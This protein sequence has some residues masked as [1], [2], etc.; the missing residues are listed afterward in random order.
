MPKLPKVSTYKWPQCQCLSSFL[1][2]VSQQPCP[3]SSQSNRCAEQPKRPS[4]TEAHLQALE[5]DLQTQCSK[6]SLSWKNLESVYHLLH[7]SFSL[8]ACLSNSL[9]HFSIQ[10]PLSSKLSPMRMLRAHLLIA[11]VVTFVLVNVIEILTFNL[12]RWAWCPHFGDKGNQS[13]KQLSE[14]TRV[15]QLISGQWWSHMVVW[16]GRGVGVGRLHPQETPINALPLTTM[17]SPSSK[18]KFWCRHDSWQMQAWLAAKCCS[19]CVCVLHREQS[20]AQW[21][22]RSC[23]SKIISLIIMVFSKKCWGVRS[24]WS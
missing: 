16:S 15:T 24:T 4:W 3:R 18:K 12:S 1:G 5:I 14:L 23:V 20:Y 17:P 19:N 6:V 21:T 22:V 2:H 13:P 11:H 10:L 8:R 7:K 9:G